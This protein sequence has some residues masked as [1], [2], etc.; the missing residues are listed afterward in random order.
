MTGMN[1]M[2]TLEE[3]AEFAVAIL[4]LLDCHKRPYELVHGKQR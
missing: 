2:A 4:A 1:R 3:I